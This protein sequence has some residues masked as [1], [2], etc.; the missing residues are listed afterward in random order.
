MLCT[1]NR[2]VG[3]LEFNV[4]FEHKYGYI[5]DERSGLESYPLTQCRKANDILTSTLAAFLFSSHRKR[6]RDREAHLNYYASAYNRGRQLSHCKIK[7]N[8][9]QQKHQIE[10]EIE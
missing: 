8:Q 10:I 3:Y 5:R 7:L 2:L 6:E 1:H 9:I 4:P